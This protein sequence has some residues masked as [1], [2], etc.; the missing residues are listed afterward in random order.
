MISI[1]LNS[2]EEATP[3]TTKLPVRIFLSSNEKIFGHL[4]L[5]S[6]DRV[7]QLIQFFNSGSPAGAAFFEVETNSASILLKTKTV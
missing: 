4:V 6:A 5:D 7:L 2:S 3:T 1:K